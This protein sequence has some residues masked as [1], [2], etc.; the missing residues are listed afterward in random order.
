MMRKT[1]MSSS[2]RWIQSTR[3]QPLSLSPQ[4]V[5]MRILVPGVRTGSRHQERDLFRI[6]N[7]TLMQSHDPVKGVKVDLRTGRAAAY[8]G[9]T[10]WDTRAWTLQERFLASRSLFF[11][12][13][14]IFWECEE[15]FWCEDSFR[16]IASISPDPH[17]TSLCGG[18]LNLS[19]NSDIV[20]FDHYYRVLLEEYSARTLTFHRD[21][22]NAFAGVIRAFERSMGLQFFWGMPTAFLESALA[23]GNRTDRL[24]RRGAFPA[25][26][27]SNKG[28]DQFP[29]WSWTG[30][31]G[32]GHSKLNTQT[33]TTSS[34]SPVLADL[35]NA[36]PVA[37]CREPSIPP[38]CLS[39]F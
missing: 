3:W 37:G 21:G 19:W 10:I 31:T 12:A 18:E 23:W 14:Q 26:D 17:R 28:Q 20:T 34:L 24:R 11:T 13:E 22:L 1:R 32:S 38:L 36:P 29:S 6:R 7:V 4:L 8:L 39:S 25:S 27:G 35:A 16:E 30:W 9:E 33:L 5:L 15:A 2:H